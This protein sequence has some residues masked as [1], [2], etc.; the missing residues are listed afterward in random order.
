MLIS[1]LH[2]KMIAG[3]SFLGETG[4]EHLSHLPVLKVPTTAAFGG[5]E[6]AL[7]YQLGRWVSAVVFLSGY[8]KERRKEKKKE[9]K[10]EHEKNKEEGEA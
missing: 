7:E 6:R 9:K 10:K 4:F 8:K 3:K 1:V 5:G 2:Q